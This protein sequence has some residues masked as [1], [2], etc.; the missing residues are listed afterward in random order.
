MFIK[1]AGANYTHRHQAKLKMLASYEHP[2]FLFQCMNGK[3]KKV[4]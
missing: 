2:G 3:E 1:I 4:L